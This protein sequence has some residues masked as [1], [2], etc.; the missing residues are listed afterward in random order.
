MTIDAVTHTAPTILFQPVVDLGTG[1]VVGY[2]ALA[3]ARG[4]D[5]EGFSALLE[6]AGSGSDRERL[7][8]QLPRLSLTR[9][10][11]RPPGT[12]LFLNVNRSV[13]EGLLNQTLDEV[14]SF[15]DVVLEVPESDR[16][17]TRW[18]HYLAPLREAGAVVAI[19]DWGVGVADPLRLVELRPKWTKIDITLTRKIGRDPEADRLIGLLV[20]FVEPS[21]GHVIAEG[22]ESA[23]QVRRLRQLGVRYG[24]GFW[25]ARPA[26]T[27][28]QAVTI[29]G[30]STRLGKLDGLP[31]ALQEAYSLTDDHLRL[32]EEQE[33]TLRPVLQGSLK[34][35]A[36][37]IQRAQIAPNLESNTTVEH[38]L[39]L[40]LRHFTLLTRGYLGGEDV[41]RARAIVQ[42]HRHYNID[43]G[44][45][46]LAYRTFQ[47]DLT[48]QLR[49]RGES[50]LAD[51]MRELLTWDMGM[52]M[53][54]YQDVMDYDETTGVW[55]RRVF[56]DR[57]SMDA[58]LRLKRN[59]KA[60][61]Q[62]IAIEGLDAG[63]RQG[64]RETSRLKLG[65]IGHALKRYQSCCTYV[66]R[67]DGDVFGIWS[68]KPGRYELT[69]WQRRIK[70]D[71]RDLSPGLTASIAQATLS[72][73]GTTVQALLNH[74]NAQLREAR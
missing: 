8:Q 29:P 65:E 68:D 41:H 57:V 58:T 61:L 37:W 56:I 15:Q 40:L 52:V 31:L 54:A 45:Y 30:R 23:E 46:V 3:R 25:L 47:A 49:E 38:F 13:V 32:I 33:A 6:Q 24:Q 18:A 1:D 21:H 48:R 16:T 69:R 59:Q 28:V 53:A 67:L 17:V 36:Q 72:A 12:L 22:V 43:L 20:N 66:G 64:H 42:A 63:R 50:A 4:R 39:A 5:E 10:A 2:E 35:L 34:M 51:A 55:R 27:F 26:A 19:D 9:A 14:L 44:W 70:R 74:A 11:L 71:V 62:V 60:L 7:L 73:Q